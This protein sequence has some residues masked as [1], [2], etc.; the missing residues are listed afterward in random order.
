MKS[1]ADVCTKRWKYVIF[2][3]ISGVQPFYKVGCYSTTRTTNIRKR[4]LSY[5]R[6]A[7]RTG[8]ELKFV[9]GESL[10]TRFHVSLFVS[11]F[12]EIFGNFAR[13]S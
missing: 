12:L 13:G 9:V 6:L 11:F 3:D 1:V 7:I 5:Q 8:T 4:T 10:N 2:A